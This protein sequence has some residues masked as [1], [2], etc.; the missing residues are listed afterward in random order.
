MKN[1][2]QINPIYGVFRDDEHLTLLLDGEIYKQV[3]WSEINYLNTTE[4]EV[5]GS[6]FKYDV[7]P[8]SGL[9]K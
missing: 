4:E 6:W 7:E 8:E 1:R 3:K 5:I 2:K 9:L